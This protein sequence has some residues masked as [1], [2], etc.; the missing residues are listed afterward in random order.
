MDQPGVTYARVPRQ[1]LRQQV[2]DDTLSRR[3]RAELLSRKVSRKPGWMLLFSFGAGVLIGW[4][5]KR[6]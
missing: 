2:T 4:L 3:S 1:A 6:R 5:V